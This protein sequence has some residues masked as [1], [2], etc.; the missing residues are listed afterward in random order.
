[1]NP[2]LNIL[3]NFFDKIYVL[4]IPSAKERQEE[5]ARTMNGLKFHFFYGIEK[6]YLDHED[7]QQSGVYDD[8]LAR[9]QQRYEK[10]MTIGDSWG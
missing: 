3:N 2:F 8:E 4:T 7:L 9:E 10:S 5:F 6:Q 1:M